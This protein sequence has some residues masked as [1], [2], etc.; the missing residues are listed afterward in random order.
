MWLN[1]EYEFLHLF[2]SSIHTE[3]PNDRMAT[4]NMVCRIQ[5][6]YE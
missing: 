5:R 2:S 1:H 3:A 6:I 4:E